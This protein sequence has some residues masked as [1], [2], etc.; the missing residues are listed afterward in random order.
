ME[1]L[2]PPHVD[3]NPP[4][5]IM[6][7]AQKLLKQL[8]RRAYTPNT[9]CIKK[10]SVYVTQI[11]PSYAAE[12]GSLGQC[13]PKSGHWN[14]GGMPIDTDATGGVFSLCSLT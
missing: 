9:T 11:E 2:A 10:V 8:E 13:F 7:R 1:Q 14:N 6:G 3:Q 5:P 4:N 12:K